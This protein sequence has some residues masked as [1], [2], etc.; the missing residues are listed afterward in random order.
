[1]GKTPEKKTRYEKRRDQLTVGTVQ[2]RGSLNMSSSNSSALGA[3]PILTQRINYHKTSDRKGR[4]GNVVPSRQIH[5][6]VVMIDTHLDERAALVPRWGL[7]PTAVCIGAHASLP[8]APSLV[9][10]GRNPP[11]VYSRGIVSRGKFLLHCTPII[12]RKPSY[13]T[14]TLPRPGRRGGAVEQVSSHAKRAR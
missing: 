11:T 9:P 1:M 7:T 4:Q 10:A 8:P 13:V 2:K 14:G 6:D 3:L 5:T 12:S